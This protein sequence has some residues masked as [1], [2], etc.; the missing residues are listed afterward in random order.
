MLLNNDTEPERDY[1][2]RMDEV[3]AEDKEKKIFAVTPKMLQLYA[4][5]LLDDAGDGYNLLGWAFQRGVGQR[6]DSERFNR[7]MNVFSACAGAAASTAPWGATSSVTAAGL[8]SAAAGFISAASTSGLSTG[9]MPNSGTADPLLSFLLA[10]SG[11]FFN[12][13]FASSA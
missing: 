13:S 9:G 8:D 11:I 3:F 1:L 2:K 12:L 5:Q 6:E 4:P 10:V 7:K